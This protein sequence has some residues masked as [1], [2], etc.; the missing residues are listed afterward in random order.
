MKHGLLSLLL[1]AFGFALGNAPECLNHIAVDGEL[2][3]GQGLSGQAACYFTAHGNSTDAYAKATQLADALGVTLHWNG[4]ARTLTFSQ[5]ETRAEISVTG[6]A[7]RGL[8]KR[9]GVF[10]IGGVNRDS[11]MGILVE[12]SSYVPVTP[13]AEAFG[14]GLEFDP[15]IGVL[16]IDTA[17]RR[18]ALEAAEREV[19]A[20]RS[21]A[22]VANR[23]AIDAP[24]VGFHEDFTRVALDL[25]PGTRYEVGVTNKN[26]VVTLGAFG[27]ESVRL[28]P[29]DNPHLESLAYAYNAD[30]G[31][32]MLVVGTKHTLQAT[33]Q[34]YRVGLLP[35]GD[36]P[37]ERLYIDFGPGLEGQNATPLTALPPSRAPSSGT[38]RSSAATSSTPATSTPTAETAPIS[39]RYRVVIDPGHGGND[40]GAQGYASEEEVVLAVALKLKALLETQGVEVILTRDGDYH[41]DASKGPDLAARAGMTTADRNL[42]VS[43][44]ANAA[45]SSAAQGVETW[46]FGQ[47]LNDELVHR[48]IEENGGGALGAALT[49]EAQSVFGVGSS[50]WRDEQLRYSLSLAERVQAGLVGKTGAK[51]RGVRQNVFYVIRNA[52][53]PAI[54]VE[55][56]FVSHPDEGSKLTTEAYQQRI[57]EG[58]AEGILGFFNGHGSLVNR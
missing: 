14:S 18:A 46:V 35:A 49:Q 9:A 48:A 10:S 41:L 28:E 47:P 20:A 31:A 33:G 25:P 12:G 29:G 15:S 4:E 30:D 19:E 51:D 38:A 23:T 7:S 43:I 27:A 56:G 54:L 32:L 16:Y 34:G 58:V 11:P 24:D 13:I 21:A 40:P 44:H 53:I 39:T 17:A 6:D 55:I 8:L 22:E 26:M 2:L 5:G 36:K 37:F 50:I 42:F 45:E 1:L 57:A 3:D 52:R